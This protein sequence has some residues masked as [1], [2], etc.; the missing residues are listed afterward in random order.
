MAPAGKGPKRDCRIPKRAS[1]TGDRTRKNSSS[2]RSKRN[3][4]SKLHAQ[5]P[6]PAELAEAARYLKGQLDWIVGQLDALVREKGARTRLRS[7]I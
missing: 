7:G 4:R 5:T 1:R 2:G 6:G 3:P